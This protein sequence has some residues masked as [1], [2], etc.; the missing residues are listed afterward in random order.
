M[1]EITIKLNRMHINFW[2]LF[3]NIF[4]KKNQYIYTAINQIIGQI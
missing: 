2:G 1:S 4:L 3:P